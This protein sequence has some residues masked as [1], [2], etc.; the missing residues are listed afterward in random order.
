MNREEIT[1]V[2]RA[3]IGIELAELS[4]L[5]ARLDAAFAQAVEAIHTSTGRLVVVGIGKSAHVGQKI[6]ATL[7]STGTPAQFLHAAE[8]FHGDLG[9]IQ[10]DDI[11]LCI[12]QSGNTAEIVSVLPF[13]KEYGKLL[14][15]LTGNPAGKLAQAADIVLD[16]NV[17]REA[18]PNA[19]APTSSTTVQMVLGDALA[20]ALMRLRNFNKNDFARFHPGGSLGKNLTATLADFLSHHKP[21]V[22]EQSSVKEVIMSISGSRHGVTAVLDDG[23]RILGVITDGDLRRTLDKTLQLEDLTAADL[24]SRNPKILETN[25]LAKE[26]MRVMKEYNIGQILVAENGRYA[27]IVD[28]HRLLDAGIN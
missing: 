6:V 3:A 16:S 28:L 2:G 24:M 19:L 20:V 13:L 21:A 5:Q 1:E 8:A 7:N 22:Q 26:A 4:R 10:A 23:G 25:A 18:C 12:S 14:I 27:G 17:Q 15:A 11:V 9:L